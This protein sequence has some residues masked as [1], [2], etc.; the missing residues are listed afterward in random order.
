MINLIPKEEEKRIIKDFYFRLATAFLFLFA[1]FMLIASLALFPSYFSALNKEKLANTQLE[2]QKNEAIP[3]LDQDAT[4]LIKD[5]DSKLTVIENSMKTRFLISEKVIDQVI[6]E[7]I[8]DIKITKISFNNDVVLGRKISVYGIA[9]NR[10]QLL[11]FKQALEKNKAFSKVDL[12]VSNFIKE[13]DIQ[14]Y[15]SLISS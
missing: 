2:A 4:A 15:L 9:K 3:Q 10:E 8:P 11:L 1:F 14:F 12:P 5:L 7:K 6:L 13:T